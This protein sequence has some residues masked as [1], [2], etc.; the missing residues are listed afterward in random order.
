MYLVADH[1]ILKEG[2]LLEYKI[3]LKLFNLYKTCGFFSSIN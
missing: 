2:D 1:I 3:F